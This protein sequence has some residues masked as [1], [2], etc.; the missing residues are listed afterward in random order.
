MHLKFSI[1][2]IL[3]LFINSSFING[4][5]EGAKVLEQVFLRNKSLQKVSVTIH[6]KERFGNKIL[7]KQGIFK[8]SYNPTKIYLKQ[9]FPDPKFEVLFLDG[10]NDNKAIVN[11]NSFPWMVLKLDPLGN[12]MRKDNHHS[13]YAS[14]FSFFIEVLEHLYTKYKG[15]F[16]G[17]ITYD[18]LTVYS[19]IECHKM[20][21][22][23]PNFGYTPYKV[24]PGENLEALARK[25]FISDY[26]VLEKNPEIK[27][28]EGLKAGMNIL[29]PTD[30]AKVFIL[31]I[32]AKT[33]TPV[34]AKIY[35]DKGL[36]EE[37]DYI[38]VNLNPPFTSL[39]FD[40]NNPAYGFK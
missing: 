19:G 35:D 22:S 38:D 10:Q 6:M 4:P 23:N 21:V 36:F 34:M 11:P 24:L 1:A 20:I 18:G 40:H 25:F 12:I 16:A 32:N 3:S 5:E 28:F 33:Y 15:D 29:I 37:Y 13:I 17:M 8:I 30:Y 9:Q 14:G 2:I 39:D 27:S 26:M 7:D 31:Y